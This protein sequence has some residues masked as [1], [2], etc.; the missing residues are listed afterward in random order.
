MRLGGRPNL[1]P[2]HGVGGSFHTSGWE[3]RNICA[4]GDHFKPGAQGVFVDDFL[5]PMRSAKTPHVP[6]LGNAC[7]MPLIAKLTW[8]TSTLL[9]FESVNSVRSRS[10]W[11]GH[12]FKSR[13]SGAVRFRNVAPSAHEENYAY[14][15]ILRC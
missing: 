10:R 14:L 4:R 9:Q 6:S 8:A 11:C 2:A 1:C 12:G 13:P 15:S 5:D 7:P 3:A